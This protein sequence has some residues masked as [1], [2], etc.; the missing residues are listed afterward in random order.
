[1]SDIVRANRHMYEDEL[2]QEIVIPALKGLDNESS[3]DVRMAGIKVLTNLCAECSTRECIALIDVL[4]RVVSKPLEKKQPLSWTETD[5]PDVR[6]SVFGLIHIFKSKLCQQPASII[7]KIYGIL[8][9][10]LEDNYVHVNVF[11]NAGSIRIEIFRLFLALRSSDTFHLGI[12][13]EATGEVK[14]SPYIVCR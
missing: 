3:L 7:T 2:F 13:N 14:Y 6:E 4:D 9:K 10:H 11:T 8:T 12:C 1:M 5:H